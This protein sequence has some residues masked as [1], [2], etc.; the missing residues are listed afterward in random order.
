MRSARFPAMGTEI[1]V[2]V[3]DS[4]RDY[5]SLVCELF[6]DWEARLSRFRPES[7]LL[8]L[9]ARAGTPVVVSELV[10]RVVAEAV[11][12]A[13]ATAGAFDPTLLHDLVRTGYDRSFD[14]IPARSV[15]TGRLPTGGGAWR[16]IVLDPGARIVELPAGC[17]L[18]L[19][20]IAKGMAVDAALDLLESLGVHT[21]LVSAGGDLAVRG[22]PPLDDAWQVLVGERRDQVIPLVR[23]ALAT[24]GIGRRSWRQ[25]GRARHHILDPVTGEPAE[26]GVREVTVAAGSCARAEAAATAAFVLGA[27]RGASFLLERGLA[28]RFTHLDGT[29]ASV[30]IWPEPSAVAA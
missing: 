6:A 29:Q 24:S 15:G 8:R 4:P 25:G 3:P 30:G 18:D 21:A 20:G 13:R 7:E 1:H 5:V 12:A 22:L 27:E 17:A 10:F 28:G 26:S 14:A 16:S 23:G 9:N 11:L 2:L 19:G